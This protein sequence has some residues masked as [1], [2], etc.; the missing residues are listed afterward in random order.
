MTTTSASI[1]TA[2]DAS[3]PLRTLFAFHVTQDFFST[4]PGEWPAIATTLRT[5][6]DDL[7]GRYG[8]HVLGTLDDDQLTVGAA[9]AGS[10]AT[11]YV[12]ADVPDLHTV[13]QICNILREQTHGPH[14]LCTFLRV[15]ARIGRPLFFA[16]R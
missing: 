6:F 5:A 1:G 9:T 8:A 10:P 15:E 13:K 4:A 12:L 11:A 2:T 7:A 16:T 3:S 14:L